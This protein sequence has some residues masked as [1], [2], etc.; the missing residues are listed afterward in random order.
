VAWP[1]LGAGVLLVLVAGYLPVARGGFAHNLQL[2]AWPEP[3]LVLWTAAVLIVFLYPQIAKVRVLGFLVFLADI[4]Y[5]LYLC[6]QLFLDWFYTHWIIPEG[7]PWP[8]FGWMTLR[9]VVSCAFSIAVAWISRRTFEA[10]FLK[11]KP[12]R[13]AAGAAAA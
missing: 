6:H 4:S 8:T 9:F 12:K 13:K 3:Y 2:A 1:L 11:M 5:G 10:F 7:A